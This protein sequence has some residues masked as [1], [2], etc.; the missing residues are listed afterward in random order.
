MQPREP[1]SEEA[2]GA[3]FQVELAQLIDLGHP[4][5]RLAEIVDWARFEESFSPLY[6]EGTGRPAIAT[7]LMAGLHYLQ[8]H[9]LSDE[10][11]VEQWVENPYWQY[12]CGGKFFEHRLPIHPTSMTRWRKKIAAAGAETMLQE[13][14]AAGLEMKVIQPASLQRVVVDTTV[15]EKAVAFPIDSKLYDDM[16][17][18]LVRLAKRAGLP[19]GKATHAVG[20]RGWRRW[21]AVRGGTMRWVFGN[22]HAS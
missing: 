19:C 11:V 6:E 10:D 1:S 2:Q 9:Q 5:A 8:L 16:R 12:L 22:I 7:R 14:I 21:A 18:Q 20:R 3:L 13:T 4:L 17:C 15:Q